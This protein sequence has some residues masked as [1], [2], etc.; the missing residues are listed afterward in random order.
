MPNVNGTYRGRLNSL[1][2]CLVGDMPD[3]ALQ[4]AGF[5]G[6]QRASEPAWDGARMTYWGTSDTMSGNGTQ[7]G[8]WANERL[9]G[10]RDWGTFEGT[11]KNEGGAVTTEG[12]FAFSGGTGRLSGISGQGTYRGRYVSPTEVE[13]EW[14]ATYQLAGRAAGG[15]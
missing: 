9:D 1:S 15:S 8:Y 5:S 14:K 11:V 13:M 6:T 12:T 10:D 7:K 4:M 3:H 2:Q